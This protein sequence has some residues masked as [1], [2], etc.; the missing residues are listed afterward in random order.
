M[1][2]RRIDDGVCE[3]REERKERERRPRRRRRL[4]HLAA[5]SAR[6]SHV[7]TSIVSLPVRT[8]SGGE[9]AAAASAAAARLFFGSGPAL[10]GS[11]S[12]RVVAGGEGRGPWVGRRV[13]THLEDRSGCSATGRL[14]QLEAARELRLTSL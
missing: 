13:P 11:L 9:A 2:K 14:R 4:P 1:N 5:R 6:P 8:G 3:E 10:A 12:S 7:A